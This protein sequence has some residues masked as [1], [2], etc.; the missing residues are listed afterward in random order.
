MGVDKPDIR[1]VIHRD[2]PPSVESYL[3]ESGR[4]GRDGKPAQAILLAT[5][6]EMAGPSVAGADS[7]VQGR[8]RQGPAAAGT[9]GTARCD[10]RAPIKPGPLAA[11]LAGSRCRRAVLVEALGAVAPECTG[12]DVCDGRAVLRAPEAA[13]VTAWLRHRR[14]RYRPAQAAVVLRG[15][16]RAAPVP[17]SPAREPVFGLLGNWSIDEVEEALAELTAAGH[18]HVIKRGPW[19]GRVIVRTLRPPRKKRSTRVAKKRIV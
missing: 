11:Y 10:S 4:A 1:S 13:A 6:R 5:P 2:L 17:W 7:A 19:R 16:A 15:V 8:A 9:P 3:Q 18:L 14:R 12:C